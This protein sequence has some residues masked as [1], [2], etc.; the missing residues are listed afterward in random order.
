ML[1]LVYNWFNVDPLL[2]DQIGLRCKFALFLIPENF[3]RQI[4]EWDEYRLC[5]YEQL[6]KRL[7]RDLQKMSSVK[8]KGSFCS[9]NRLWL[10]NKTETNVTTLKRRRSP[11]PHLDGCDIECS[12]QISNKSQQYAEEANI[13]ARKLKRNSRPRRVQVS[14]GH[15]NSAGGRPKLY[16]EYCNKYG[17]LQN[18][19]RLEKADM[20]QKLIKY[21]G[22]NAY[23]DF[24][25]EHKRP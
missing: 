19:C 2:K 8:E 13:K 23:K 15:A 11:E 7:N 1:H 17:H 10:S 3:R 16:C 18:V 12:S 9:E 14:E 21:K 20:I 6:W 22:P 25:R 24:S 5:D 4:Y